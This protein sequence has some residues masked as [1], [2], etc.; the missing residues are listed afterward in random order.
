MKSEY[1]KRLAALAL[2]SKDHDLM[3]RAIELLLQ[4]AAE[5]TPKPEPVSPMGMAVRNLIAV[6]KISNIKRPIN[7][8]EI[9]DRILA[10]LS[11][12]DLKLLFPTYKSDDPGLLRGIAIEDG[13]GNINAGLLVD[14][15]I[16]LHGTGRRFQLRKKAK[17]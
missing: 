3:V 13:L 5:N 17:K 1:I 14:E 16:C 15:I 2:D 12:E 9:T 6:W 4:S 8:T 11:G 7:V 10:H